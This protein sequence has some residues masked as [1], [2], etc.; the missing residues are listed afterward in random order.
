M[1]EKSLDDAIGR[2]A[3]RLLDMM[4]L[5]R[6]EEALKMIAGVVDSCGFTH[7]STLVGM[8]EI[9][10]AQLVLEGKTA[11]EALEEV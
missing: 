3:K 10:I 4:K 9:T 11:H 5:E 6:Y 2:A 8:K 1:D 7:G